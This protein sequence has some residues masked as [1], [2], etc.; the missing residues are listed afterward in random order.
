MKHLRV[1]Q[2]SFEAARRFIADSNKQPDGEFVFV[3]IVLVSIIFGCSPVDASPE[4]NWD[5]LNAAAVNAMDTNRYWIA[6]PLLKRSVVEAE[7]FGSDSDRLATALHELGRYYT[8]RGRF[9]EAEPLFERELQVREMS[10]GK[11]ADKIVPAMGSLIRFHLS[12][13][14]PTKGDALTKDMLALLDGKMRETQARGGTFKKGEPMT[15]WC[16]TASLHRDPLLEWA[17]TCDT[18]GKCYRARGNFE[19]GEKL[20]KA[21]LDMKTTILGAGHLSLAS[22]YAELGSLYM[23]H[24]DFTQAEACFREAYTSTELVLSPESPEVYAQIDRLARCLIKQEKYSQAEELYL[25]GLKNSRSPLAK[26]GDEARA[27]YA[28]GCLY[29]EQRKF[30]AAAPCLRT[31]LESN[32]KFNGPCQI[33]L[34]PYLEKYAYCLYYLGSR[35]ETDRLRARADAILGPEGVLE[36]EQKRAEAMRVAVKIADVSTTTATTKPAKRNVKNGRKSANTTARNKRQHKHSK[37]RK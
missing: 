5:Q 2:L 15:A 10:L 31:A 16:G 8:I 26:G 3:L 12:Y 18:I 11:D 14:T 33:G 28:L 30:A 1:P 37:H 34:V 36:R 13:G 29:I 4:S 19:L 9:T 24:L 21:S 7:K 35:G 17:I 23:E 25:K 6:H 20:F 27:L 22:T 32:A